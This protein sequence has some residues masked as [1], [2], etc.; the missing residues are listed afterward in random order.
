MTRLGLGYIRWQVAYQDRLYHVDGMPNTVG[1]DI[2]IAE[3]RDI[4]AMIPATPEEKGP[5]DK[6][7]NIGI[8][9]G[10]ICID[11]IFKEINKPEE[12]N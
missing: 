4:L 2:T 6:C 12:T 10:G 5:C 1:F 11:C 9:S 8:T 7:H 3:M